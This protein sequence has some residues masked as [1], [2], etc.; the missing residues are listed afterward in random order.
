MR[1]LAALLTSCLIAC[2]GAK[3][4]TTHDPVRE[5]P[6]PNATHPARNQ[7]V[8]VPSWGVG[9]N[10]VFL[11]AS[12]QE[13]RPTLV[14]LHGL[15]GNEQNLDLAQAIR[16]S[17]WNVLTLHYRGSWGSPGR[18]SIAGAVND[19]AAAVAFVR[20]DDI[21]AKY[22]IDARRVVIGG[23]SMGGFA[24]ARYAATH[25]DVVGLILLDAW[26]VG[27]DAT[28]LR[29]EPTR[30]AKF[31]ADI[32]DLGNSLVGATPR[33]LTDEVIAS[34]KDWDLIASAPRLARL[35][36]LTIWADRGFAKDN[37]ALA[38]AIQRADPDTLTAM[39][40]PS[41]H[42]F[43]DSRIALAQAVVRWLDGVNARNRRPP[44]P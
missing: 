25:D 26:N 4:P 40:I 18:F 27:A 17:G 23:H 21:A 19:A 30:R 35:P 20:R 7:Q 14:L 1:I 11:L 31:E 43:A 2:T 9:M 6:V 44:R 29:A 8:L 36:V 42:A 34:G 38:A 10:A 13:R 12:G 33:S 3:S 24:A 16:R 28:A 37:A 41:D 39:H 32:D 5:D 22:G 15:P